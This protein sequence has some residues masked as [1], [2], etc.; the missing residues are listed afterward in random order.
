M[1]HVEVDILW[2]VMIG[3]TATVLA[4]CGYML[5]L[6]VQDWRQAHPARQAV[7]SSAA[8]RHLIRPF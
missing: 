4:I 6:A 8:H 2:V 1:F 3:C 5:Q 7:A